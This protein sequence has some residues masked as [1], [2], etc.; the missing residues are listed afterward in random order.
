[1]RQLITL[2]LVLPLFIMSAC[3][4]DND[5]VAE[6]KSGIITRGD[7]RRWLKL[8]D[9]KDESEANLKH[10]AVEKIAAE[11][12]VASKFDQTPFFRN[13]SRA[14][15]NNYLSSYYT[16]QIK[17]RL[18]FNERA[19]EFS[20]IR[21]YY[22]QQNTSV[23]NDVVFNDKLALARYIIQQLNGRADFAG[24][25]KI[26]SEER[27]ADSARDYRIV[28]V[29]IL[30]K[31]IYEKIK[32]LHD[33]EHTD[34]PV[35]LKDSIAVIKFSRWV[36]LDRINS[37]RLIE[38][39]N[40]YNRFMDSLSEGELEY[41][42]A[43]NSPGLAIR[44]YINRAG[45]SGCNEILF[46]INEEPFTTGDLLN[47]LEMFRFLGGGSFDR[48]FSPNER[49][50]AALNIFNETVLAAIAASRGIS[51]E[52]EFLNNWDSIRKSSLAGAYKYSIIVNNGIP[53]DPAVSCGIRGG[54]MTQDYYKKI[55]EAKTVWEDD[56]LS[57]F[58][59]KLYRN[60]LK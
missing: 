49:K 11:A 26:Y 2:T 50:E 30:E 1:M 9:D 41:I 43:E 20:I 17:N 57:S 42:I 24:L 48:N 54:E 16:T 27:G 39:R 10:M 35:V 40:L 23:K 38:D 52:R 21:L 13:I 34:V 55:S 56:L 18:V 45:F 58:N 32:T 51:G 14:I 46:S 33:G 28:P 36:N 53:V 22:S 3:S 19:A 60:K 12:A 29:L 15:Y 7:F 37:E 31:E 47:L 59:F 44:N 4:N 5:V 6:M 25:R 8:R